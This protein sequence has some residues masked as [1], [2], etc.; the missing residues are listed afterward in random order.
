IIGILGLAQEPTSGGN[1]GIEVP[2]T[3]HYTLTEV[4][5]GRFTIQTTL[6]SD[7]DVEQDG[8]VGTGNMSGSGTSSGAVDN[9]LDSAA[10]FTMALDMVSDID[11]EDMTMTLNVDIEVVSVVP[12]S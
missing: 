2:V 5:D 10:S 3:Y 1:Q 6:D 4:R 9:P 11:G 7:F 12:A 8:I